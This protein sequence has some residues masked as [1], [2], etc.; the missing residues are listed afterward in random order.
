MVTQLFISALHTQDYFHLI[1]NDVLSAAM[2]FE[3]LVSLR[4]SPFY[5]SM[6]ATLFKISYICCAILLLITY[7]ASILY[8]YR[9]A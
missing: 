2:R 9:K 5:Y 3:C 6:L 7:S 8:C 4:L 1:C